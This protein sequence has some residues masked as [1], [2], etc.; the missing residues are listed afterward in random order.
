MLIR[1]LL[2]LALPLLACIN[3]GA[4]PPAQAIPD[5]NFMELNNSLFTNRNLQPGKMSLFIFFDPDCEH[6]QHAIMTI[7]KQYPEYKKI[8]IYLVSVA[9]PR[10]IIFFMDTYG[11]Q[12]AGKKNVKVLR[13][14]QNQFISR[15]RPV[16]I[17]PFFYIQLKRN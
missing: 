2:K 1:A 7:N 13:D 10:Q 11:R 12:L 9:N 16:N 15:F 8:M 3:L 4:Q 6:C 17:P 5:F 14:T